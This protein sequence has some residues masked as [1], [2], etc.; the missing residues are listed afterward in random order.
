MWISSLLFISFLSLLKA[1]TFVSSNDSI[2]FIGDSTAYLGYVEGGF[3]HQV[4]DKLNTFGIA[5]V[6]FASITLPE[7]MSSITALTDSLEQL[8]PGELLHVPNP[9]AP[10]FTPVPH[11]VFVMV[12]ID[13]INRGHSIE[14]FSVA[15]QVLLNTLSRKGAINIFLVSPTILGEHYDGSNIHDD[16]IEEFAGLCE[17]IAIDWEDYRLHHASRQSRIHGDAPLTSQ[18]YFVD[19]R[20]EILKRLER[21]NHENLPLG[22]FTFDGKHFN[23]VGHD[24]ISTL[25]VNSICEQCHQQWIHN[26]DF[27]A[28]DFRPN[29]IQLNPIFFV[30]DL[31]SELIY[32][33]EL[34]SNLVKQTD[35]ADDRHDVTMQPRDEF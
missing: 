13:E 28:I 12:G 4:I 21:M 26:Y 6:S 11:T 15:L 16:S 3:M 23:S 2:L 35:Q 32:N 17:H 7:S 27:E 5:N 18:V 10:I 22:I 1:R 33:I 24:L 25:F 29:E 31:D 14:D 9:N 19:T 8:Y 34:V 30:S 20:M